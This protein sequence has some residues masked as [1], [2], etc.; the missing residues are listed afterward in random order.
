MRRTLLTEELIVQFTSAVSQCMPE[1]YA[2][3]LI[4]VDQSTIT[5]WKT[6]ANLARLKKPS[7][8]TK[9][10]V[11]YLAF[12]AQLE[13][14]RSIAR[15]GRIKVVTKAGDSG[16]WQAAAWWL[17]RMCPES[18]G[19]PYAIGI[20]GKGPDSEGNTGPV[21]IIID[22]AIVPGKSDGP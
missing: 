2:A 15:F 9:N 19:R 21:T 1:R 6:A 16:A 13:K 14:A 17:E 18:F 8:L 22:G 11:Q 20:P 7:K 4:G 10:D 12:I 5:N 3:E